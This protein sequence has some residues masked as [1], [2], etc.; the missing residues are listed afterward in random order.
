MLVLTLG[1]R[2]GDAKKL[3]VTFSDCVAKAEKTDIYRKKISLFEQALTLHKVED[4]D[5]AKIKILLK[6]ADALVREANGDTGYKG[7]IALKVTHKPEY[8][9]AQYV[10]ARRDLKEIENKVSA[11]SAAEQALYTELSTSLEGN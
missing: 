5:L 11:L 8:K 6:K 7:E 9:E 3:C 10:K 4:G 1:V 2:A